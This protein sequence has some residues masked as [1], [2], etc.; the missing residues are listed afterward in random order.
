MAD[1]CDQSAAAG[2]ILLKA[3]LENARANIG[4]NNGVIDRPYCLECGE[5]IP[6]ARRQAVPGVEL[7]VLC[8]QMEENGG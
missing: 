8:K 7:C 4:G 1:Y 5:E 2:E 6:E 3:A